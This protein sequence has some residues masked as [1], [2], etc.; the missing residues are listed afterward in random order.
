MSPI[1]LDATEA[2]AYLAVSETALHRLA[3]RGELPHTQQGDERYFRVEDLDAYLRRR[4]AM[5]KWEYLFVEVLEE[6][7]VPRPATVN[8]RPLP[9]WKRGPSI[10]QYADDLGDEGWELV[11]AHGADKG[12]LAGLIFKRPKPSAALARSPD[13]P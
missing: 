12:V 3:A 7:H 8:G 13:E 4:S 10:Y 5:P 9:D 1:I 6:K 2:A 11:G